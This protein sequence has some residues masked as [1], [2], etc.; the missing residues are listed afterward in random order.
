VH[1][2]ETYNI[3]P[4]STHYDKNTY[5][6]NRLHKKLFELL[7]KFKLCMLQNRYVYIQITTYLEDEYTYTLF[8]SPKCYST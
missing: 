7:S 8:I 2:F 5:L 6:T 3:F 1:L 4:I